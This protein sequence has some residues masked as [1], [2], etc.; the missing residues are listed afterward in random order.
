M[1]DF[2][3]RI[4]KESIVDIKAKVSVPEKE[5]QGST[6]KIELHITEIWTVNRSVPMLPFQLEDA[7]RKVEN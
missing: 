3:R 1:V 4:P 2:A 6:Q 5:I 7:S